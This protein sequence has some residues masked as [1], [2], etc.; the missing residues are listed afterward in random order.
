LESIDGVAEAAAIGGMVR[1]YQVIVDPGRLRAYRVTVAQVRAAIEGGNRETGGSVIELAEAEYAVRANG[2]V[3]SVDDLRG[4]PV[5]LG[6]RGVPV[7]LRDLAEVRVGPEMRRGIAE[8]DGEGEVAGGVVILRHGADARSTLRAVKDRLGELARRLP[9]GVEIVPTYDRSGLIDRAV[10]NLFGKLGQELLVVLVVCIV[11]LHHLR[12]GLVVIALLPLA[13]LASLLA[14]RA[15]GVTANIMSLGGIAIA[16]GAM[17]DAAIVMVENVHKRLEHGS[18][19]AAQVP[20]ARSR[21][22]AEACIEVGPAL[23][24]SLLIV[25]LSFVPV[26]VLEAQEG[27]LFAPLAY[28]KTYAMLAAA[29]A[30]ITVTPVLISMLVRGR[31]RS[32]RANPVNRVSAAV[33]RPLLAF[34]LRRPWWVILGALVVVLLSIWPLSRLG[35]EFMPDMDEGD[36]L[37]MPITLP[38]ISPDAVRALLQ[39]TDRAIKEVPEVERVFGKAGRAETATDPAPFEMLETVVRLK[40]PSEWRDGLT[41]GELMAELD[42]RVR[43]P[44]LAN[45][46]LPPIRSRVDMLSTGARTPLGMRITGPNLDEIARIAADVERIV[47]SVPGAGAVFAERASGG[48]YID[49]DI[50]RSAAARYGLNIE[51]V[52]EVIAFAVGGRVVAESIEGRERYPINL[53]Y[54]QEWRDSIERLQALPVVTARDA[55]IS[56]GDI[57]RIRVTEGPAMIRSENAQLAGLIHITPA[58]RDLKAFVREAQRRIEAQNAVPAGYGVHWSGQY[59]HLVRAFG[60]LAL[61]VPLALIVVV[62][63]LYMSSRN[64][65]DVLLILG[66]LPVALV[67]GAWLLWLLGYQ[68][69]VAVAVGFVALAG[70]AIETGIVMQLYLNTAWDARRAARA[71]PSRADL[72]EAITEGALLRLRP[73]LMTV[74]IIIAALMPIM[75]GHGTGSE[76]MRRIATPMVGGMVSAMLLTLVV[77]PAAFLLINQRRI[78]QSSLS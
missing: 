29:L 2:Y 30:S 63:L 11:F 69:S 22:V 47:R 8:L 51:D 3:T 42:S 18:G 15:Q 48:R 46:W 58:T 50:D 25:A 37:Y 7:L 24:F 68:M 34:A 66:S 45:S 20:H 28:T 40:P 27:R 23:F 33:Y 54:P 70:V 64:V 21:L 76:V 61:V 31:L 14:M 56:L 53:R 67:G 78:S 49:V 62:I 32:E 38:G 17:V 41:A 4:I 74:T 35:T 71:N 59:E 39:Q 12:S 65:P 77:I 13:V 36:L 10:R 19:G 43:L 55:S 57:A 26:L 1:Q 60:R 52:H 9:P 73:K 44:G 16:I 72:V 75:L 6:E 5:K